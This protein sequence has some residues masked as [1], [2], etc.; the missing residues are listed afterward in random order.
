MKIKFLRA[1]NGDAIFLEIPIRGDKTF[2]ILVDGG[3]PATYDSKKGGGEL[4]KL[5]EDLRAS[6]HHIDLLILT[7]IDDD[8][9]G[10]VLKF[11]QDDPGASTFVKK[12]WFNSGKLIAEYLQDPENPDLRLPLLK[13]NSPN[14]SIPDGMEFENFIAENKIWD[15]R[16]ILA[17]GIT[18]L[19]GIKFW[20]LSPD[21]SKL[22]KLLKNWK[23]VDTEVETTGKPSDFGKS[24]M[25]HIEGDEFSEDSAIPNGSSIAFILEFS[26]RNFLF[27]ADAHPSVL[28]A[29]LRTFG[30]SKANPIKAELV[31][32]S[33]HGSASNNSSELLEMIDC[34]EY[35]ISTNGEIHN[36]P[37]KRLLARLINLKDNCNIYFNYPELIDLIFTQDDKKRYK[38]EAKPIK[39]FEYND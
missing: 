17:E 11:F 25:E 2:R 10:G 21:D 39:V 22:K 7:H 24:L 28:S 13:V 35:V 31:K 12:V 14:T 30:F 32:I 19:H 16:I 5:I 29:S 23:R 20:F 18:E 1:Y 4:K 36:H 15:R 8:H 34:S 26:G 38:F 6:K 27:L 33:H 37:H 3:K 9:I